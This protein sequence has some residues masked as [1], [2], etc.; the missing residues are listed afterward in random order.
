MI[1]SHAQEIFLQ[2]EKA[3]LLHDQL[4]EMVKSPRYNT[5]LVGQTYDPKGLHF[6][7]KYMVYMS[8][9]RKMDHRQYVANLKLMTKVQR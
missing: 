8:L 1:Y 6:I 2:S 7:E 4:Q 5:K 3:K 9:H